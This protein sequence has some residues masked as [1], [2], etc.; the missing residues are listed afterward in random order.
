MFNPKR[1]ALARRRKGFKK[2][3]LAELLHLHPRAITAFESGEYPPSEETITKASSVL[4]FPR[5]FFFEEELEEPQ[6]E[7][8]SFRSMSKMTAKSRNSAVAAAS[9]AFQL[10]TWIEPRFALPKVDLLDLKGE[11]AGIAA[12]LVRQHWGI[13]ERSIRNVVH[14]LEAKGVRVF[15]LAENTEEVDAFSVWHNGKP[16]MFLNTLKSAERGRY[17]AA[18]ELA[19]LILHKH[20]APNGQEAEKQAD[21]FAS[22]FL[23]PRSTVL[24]SAPRSPTV[25]H[26]LALKQRWIVSAFALA[27]RFH[28]LGIL[29][30]WHYRMLCQEM[31]SR[32][33]RKNE[34]NSVQRETSRLWEKIFVSL[35]ADGISKNDIARHL[36]LSVEEIEKLVWGLVTMGIATSHGPIVRSK[37]RANLRLVD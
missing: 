13:G 2:N 3:R 22:S 15:S 9:F 30:D 8:V 18:H 1:F 4:G 21:A 12:D 10:M 16:Y 26:I 34:P 35:R 31:S 7:W 28:E 24:A 11:S 27:R 20:G 37:R 6:A 29:S 23:M 5:E 32:G 33:Y 19:H 36:S 17:D 14:L 25:Q